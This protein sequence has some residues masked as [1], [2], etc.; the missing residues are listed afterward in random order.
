MNAAGMHRS[1]SLLFLAVF[2]VSAQPLPPGVLTLARILED[3]ALPAAGRASAIDVRA[4]CYCGRSRP[5]D[6]SS[7]SDADNAHKCVG[8]INDVDH[9][10]IARTDA[11]QVLV[12]P[13]LLASR[14]PWVSV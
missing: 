9:T 7:V 13:E 8:V 3:P 14:G 12:S 6:L 1:L 10:V 5:V 11:P 2:C 4:G